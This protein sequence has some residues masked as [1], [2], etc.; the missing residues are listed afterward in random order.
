MYLNFNKHAYTK[1]EKIPENNYA[2][3]YNE[4]DF[5]Y[6]DSLETMDGEII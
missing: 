6:D 5:A 2:K 1:L 4:E 3:A